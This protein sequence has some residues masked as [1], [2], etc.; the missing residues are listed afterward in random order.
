[1]LQTY[2]YPEVIDNLR[3]K[4]YFWQLGEKPIVPSGYNTL[5]WAKFTKLLHS[6]V[7][8]GTTS[9]DGVTP[10]DTAFNATVVNCVP[11]QLRI[12]VNI[13][14][15]VYKL[16]RIDF[17][18]GAAKEVAEAIADKIDYEIQAVVMAGTRYFYSGDATTR[19]GL[20]SG[21]ELEWAEIKTVVAWLRAAGAPTYDGDSYAAV[22]HPYVTS[23]VMADTTTKP[24][25]VDPATY[26]T[27]DKI[28]NGEIGKMHGVRFMESGFVQ[29]L[30]TNVYPT[31]VCGRGAFGVADFSSLEVFKTGGVESDSDPAAQ[32]HKV[33]AKMAFNSV[34]LDNDR[35]VR[36]ESF[37]A[38]VTLD[39]L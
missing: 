18:K 10:S 33:A 21:D 26:T 1:V 25:W 19:A 2:L 38:G 20:N 36:V 28:W 7:T 3:S 16:N 29:T 27:P 37:S 30:A 13:A 31:L 8:K 4:L 39:T 32:R 24:N 22:I 9:N 23:D 15:M 6:D 34:I 35:M 17:L 14:D 5:S 12:V 11:F